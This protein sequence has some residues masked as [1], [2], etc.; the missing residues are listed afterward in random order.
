VTSRALIAGLVY[1]FIWEGIVTE[2]F[3]GTQFLSVRQYSLG[4]ADLIADTR[5]DIFEAELSGATA[6]VMMG[7][8]GAGAVAL[9]V[10]RLRSLEISQ[11]A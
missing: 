4:V 8:V 11:S 3:S 10:R 9:A 6:L 7:I 5:A 1:V 2:L